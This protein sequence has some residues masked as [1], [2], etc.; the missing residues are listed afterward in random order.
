VNIAYLIWL[1]DLNNSII[2]GQVIEMLMQ[3]KSFLKQDSL[4]LVQFRAIYPFGKIDKYI[5]L[6][7]E[8]QKKS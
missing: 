3:L 4:Y 1:E 7:K 6:K 2:K 8:L 5:S